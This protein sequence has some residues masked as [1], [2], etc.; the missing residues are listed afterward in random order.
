MALLTLTGLPN[1]AQL[2][3]FG[4]WLT[5]ADALL[6]REDARPLMWQP[7]PTRARG[8]VR[9]TDADALGGL[10]H[11]DWTPITDRHWVEL[12]AEHQPQ[13]TW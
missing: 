11:P 10:R 6:L 2:E 5:T 13:L 7:N 8:Y 3:L 9:Q 1:D 4:L 12:V